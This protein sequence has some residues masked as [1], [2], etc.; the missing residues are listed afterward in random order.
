MPRLLVLKI[1]IRVGRLPN[2]I[3]LP[4]EHVFVLTFNCFMCLCCV[5]CNIFFTDKYIT[6]IA[7]YYLYFMIRRLC[8]VVS[9]FLNFPSSQFKG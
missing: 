7:K 8:R 4:F 2:I 1:G 6:L 9:V 5:S 3:L